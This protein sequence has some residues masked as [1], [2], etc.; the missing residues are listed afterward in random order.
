MIKSTTLL[1]SCVWLFYFF[2]LP[3]I[4]IRAPLKGLFHNYDCVSSCLSTLH[5]GCLANHNPSW[6]IPTLWPVLFTPFCFSPFHRP[7]PPVSCGPAPAL[8][9]LFVTSRPFRELW[10][11]SVVAGFPGAG[12]QFWLDAWRAR[13]PW[14]RWVIPE[15]LAPLWSWGQTFSHGNQKSNKK[16]R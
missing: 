13:R 8:Q 4:S 6:S 7:Y 1:A 14:S 9:Q 10:P 3:W 5:R 16:E 15:L 11:P 2:F 12:C